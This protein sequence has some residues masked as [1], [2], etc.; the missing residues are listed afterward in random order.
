MVICDVTVQSSRT[1]NG[2]TNFKALIQK[3]WRIGREQGKM[4]GRLDCGDMQAAL[5]QISL[6]GIADDEGR[7]RLQ[8]VATGLAI[9]DADVDTLVA[10]RKT[11]AQTHPTLLDLIPDP[12]G[13]SEPSL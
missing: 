2:M 5:I 3:I 4:L 8:A 7:R 6:A 9:P 11:L 12:D 1:E 10:K 13:T